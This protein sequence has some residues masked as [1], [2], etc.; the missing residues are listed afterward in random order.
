MHAIVTALT[1]TIAAI[2]VLAIMSQYYLA[3]FYGVTDT[4]LACSFFISELLTILSV[5]FQNRL[6]GQNLQ[7]A[8]KKMENIQNCLTRIISESQSS[9]SFKQLYF[10]KFVINAAFLCIHCAVKY[11]FLSPY[12]HVLVQT[13]ILSLQ[14]FSLL[15]N[16][17]M[18]FYIVV[19]Q[20]F[21][22]TLTRHIHLS[23]RFG[24]CENMYAN[25]NALVEFL[26]QYKT[27]HFQIW[28]AIQILNSH[29]G[30]T[31]AAICIQNAFDINYAVYWI[32][33]YVQSDHDAFL[34]ISKYY[35]IFSSL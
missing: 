2:F 26:V 21:L 8:W 14:S 10:P 9:V 20:Y 31:L 5:Y 4:C 29:F 35:N 11:A 30:W 28:D 22:M 33:L 19:I 1:A 13:S 32:F 3:P 12:T 17:H 7:T 24:L 18:L 16:L 27:I 23:R 34:A 15:V 25:L 6:F